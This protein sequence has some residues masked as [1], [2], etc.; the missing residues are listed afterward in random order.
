MPA[1]MSVLFRIMLQAPHLLADA[2]KMVEDAIHGPGGMGK[3][4][5]VVADLEKMLADATA[6][7]G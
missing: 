4:T 5:E 2:Y 6:A 1:I 3:I 7:A